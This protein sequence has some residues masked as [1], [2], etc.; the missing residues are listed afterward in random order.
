V[1]EYGE[2]EKTSSLLLY[3]GC[4]APAAFFSILVPTS[5]THRI[6]YSMSQVYPLCIYAR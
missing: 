1:Q 6:A 3:F 5:R 4:F 2:I